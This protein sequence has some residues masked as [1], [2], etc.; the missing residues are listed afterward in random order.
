MRVRKIQL[1]VNYV[2]VMF[3]FG[4][5]EQLMKASLNMVCIRIVTVIKKKEDENSS[6]ILQGCAG[7]WKEGNVCEC[8]GYELRSD[9]CG[10]NLGAARLGSDNA[11]EARPA[12]DCRGEPW[13]SKHSAWFHFRATRL[14]QGQPNI[15]IRCLSPCRQAALYRHGYRPVF[16]RVATSKTDWERLPETSFSYKEVDI[17]DDNEDRN[18]NEGT[19]YIEENEFFVGP[20]RSVMDDNSLYPD[21]Y[22]ENEED[23]DDDDIF[24]D[25]MEIGEE[26]DEMDEI[27]DN[28]QKNFLKTESTLVVDEL[29]ST[30]KKTATK[31][32]VR[33]KLLLERAWNHIH[34]PSPSSSSKKKKRKKTAS[35]KTNKK[36]VSEKTRTKS[37]MTE[38][39]W[40]CNFECIHDSYEFAFCYP[41]SVSDLQVRLAELQ[42]VALSNDQIF[43]KRETLTTSIDGRR[44]EVLTVTDSIHSQLVKDEPSLET[45]SNFGRDGNR[46]RVLATSVLSERTGG[47]S[48]TIDS[49]IEDED[50]SA[51][52]STGEETDYFDT[53]S[54]EHRPPTRTPFRLTP[55]RRSLIT[56][57]KR[58]GPP[59]ILISGRVHP[60]ETPSSFVIDGLLSLL[61]DSEQGR[62]LRQ[63]FVWRLVPMLNPDGVSRGH[64]RRDSRGEDLNRRYWPDPDGSKQPSCAALIALAESLSPRLFAVIDCHAHATKRGCFIF[65]NYGNT[66]TERADGQLL[67]ALLAARSPAFEFEGSDFSRRKMISVPGSARVAL[68]SYRLCDQPEDGDLTQQ[69]MNRRAW[70]HYNFDTSYSRDR[71]IND[72]Y[73][74]RTK[75][76]KSSI[77]SIKKNSFL[78][79]EWRWC[80]RA[81]TLEC[82][83]NMG[84]TL[85]PNCLQDQPPHSLRAKL[86]LDSEPSVLCQPYTTETW[87]QVGRALALSLLDLA[88]ADDPSFLTPECLR[89]Q[90][91]WLAGRHLNGITAQR[92]AFGS[93]RR[94]SKSSS[95]PPPSRHTI[96]PLSSSSKSPRPR[97]KASSRSPTPSIKKR[98][99]I[100]S[101]KSDILLPQ[102]DGTGTVTDVRQDDN[103]ASTDTITL[104]TASIISSTSNPEDEELAFDS[105]ELVE[106]SSA[107]NEAQ[108]KYVVQI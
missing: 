15:T 21:F 76:K 79:S 102:K 49:A 55:E 35:T 75:H 39:T 17:V 103:D 46:R 98:T 65:G 91:S 87:R 62:E 97:K 64:F 96:R 47:L 38:L 56:N 26:N 83:Y 5:F 20:E 8:G 4:S 58:E 106:F 90:A 14:S 41:Y 40:K 51:G 67:A 68:R 72:D 9:F 105:A 32:K 60:G 37:R 50:L 95:S 88:Y 7:S 2:V 22:S 1:Q 31:K 86:A 84:H 104:T 74:N 101:A 43:F 28:Q 25:V 92:L 54:S 85:D 61:L 63:R 16:R 70:I 27:D 78:N 73:R 93:L 59:E 18:Q 77:L 94:R 69:D 29:A 80:P 71:N 13:Q 81:Y 99:Q 36:K 24:F 82:N 57:Q 10:G 23:D 107:E 3:H 42:G 108:Y 6:Q 34:S 66:A 53:R 44:I 33:K 52:D 19:N 89:D 30:G 48:W 11:L 100:T 45:S 12:Q